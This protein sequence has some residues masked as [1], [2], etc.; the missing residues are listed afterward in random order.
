MPLIKLNA[1]Q[2]LTG[3]LPAVSG[4]NLT[5]IASD[6]VKIVAFDISSSTASVSFEHGTSGVDFTGTTYRSHLIIF[7]DVHMVDDNDRIYVQIRDS[8][9]S[10]DNASNKYFEN[11]F[12]LMNDSVGGLSG[13]ESSARLSNGGTDSGRRHSTIEGMIN[14]FNFN[15]TTSQSKVMYQTHLSFVDSQTYH[16]DSVGTHCRDDEAATTG[17]KLIGGSG[18]IEA[19]TFTLYSR[20]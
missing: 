7:S 2:G 20:K 19:G 17:I 1:T 18:S 12:H 10:Y 14:L 6:F 3:T 16:N 11:R 4:A 5:G 8:G 15:T 13:N 9:G